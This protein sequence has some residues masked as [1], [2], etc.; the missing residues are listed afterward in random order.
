MVAKYCFKIS[1]SSL[2]CTIKT[3]L[4]LFGTPLGGHVTRHTPFVRLSVR[5][6]VCHVITVNSITETVQRLNLPKKFTHVRSNWQ[7]NVEGDRTSCQ[8]GPRLLLQLM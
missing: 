8:H 7:N 6:S 4:L 2:L 3:L 5:L 1:V